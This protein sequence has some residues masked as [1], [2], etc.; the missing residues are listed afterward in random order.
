M[1][2]LVPAALGAAASAVLLRRPGSALRLRGLTAPARAAPGRRAPGD[3]RGGVP[4]GVRG[5]ASAE[6]RR[7]L[8]PR[9]ACVVAAAGIVVLVGGPVGLVLAAAVALAGPG[10]LGRLEPRADRRR[11]EQLARDLP[12]ALDLLAACLTGGA[13]LAD[14][15]RAVAGAVPGPC[16][17]RLEQVAAAL[18]VGSPA[19]EAWQ[20]L[21]AGDRLE[22]ALRGPWPAPATGAPPSRRPSA[23]LPRRRE[24]R[25]LLAAPEQPAGRACWP[26]LPSDSA[27]CR[28]SSCSASC[29]QS[30]V[31][32]RRCWPRCGSSATAAAADGRRSRR[33]PTSTAPMAVVDDAGVRLVRHP[34]KVQPSGRELEGPVRHVHPEDL[35]E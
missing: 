28:R 23:A 29:R 8:G 18:A 33:A 4:G 26:S 22:R 32:P 24:P 19:A 1:S 6:P 31:L 10:L 7:V 5:P 20:A 34:V 2:V 11:S 21:G 25:P 3:V 27:S 14:A 16:C 13:S 35:A 17:T 30:S 9:T 15:V 12:L